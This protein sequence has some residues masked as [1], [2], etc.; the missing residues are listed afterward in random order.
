MGEMRNAYKILV[1]N[2]KGRDNLEDL[3]IDGGPV[4]ISCE[5]GDEPLSSIKGGGFLD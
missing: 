2:L 3:G 5:H 1:V 4:A